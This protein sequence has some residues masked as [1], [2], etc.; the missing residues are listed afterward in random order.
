VWVN[1]VIHHPASVISSASIIRIHIHRPHSSPSSIHRHQRYPLTAEQAVHRNYCPSRLRGK[2]QPG[3]PSPGRCGRDLKSGKGETFARADRCWGKETGGLRF[4]KTHRTCA[5]QGE[6]HRPCPQQIHLQGSS[7]RTQKSGR[8]H[9]TPSFQ[10]I[11]NRAVPI[12]WCGLGKLKSADYRSRR[13]GGGR[14]CGGPWLA[15]Q[16]RR[17]CMTES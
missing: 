7:R 2:N 14:D 3:L 17:Q 4:C 8:R 11:I 1:T 5:Q 12:T 10:S 15:E 13:D 9:L 16:I 6:T